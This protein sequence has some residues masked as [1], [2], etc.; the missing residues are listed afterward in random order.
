MISAKKSVT[1]QRV[2]VGLAAVALLASTT[3]VRLVSRGVVQIE[4]E[5]TVLL[6]VLIIDVFESPTVGWALGWLL[7]G[8]AF[9]AVLPRVYPSPTEATLQNTWGV[10]AGIAA[11]TVVVGTVVER[12][13]M[14]LEVQLADLT[15]SPLPPLGGTVVGITLI[16]ASLG[17]FTLFAVRHRD[18]HLVEDG[19]VRSWVLAGR[20]IDT[21]CGTESASTFDEV[22]D[23][24]LKIFDTL[25]S[26]L[27]VLGILALGA[28]AATLLFPVIELVTLI[29]LVLVWVSPNWTGQQ[30]ARADIE[31]QL[32]EAAQV[33]RFGP[34]GM[35]A[36]VLVGFGMLPP[37]LIC[38]FTIVVGMAAIQILLFG[39]GFT[40]SELLLLS[41]GLVVFG[42]YG[43]YSLW[44]WLRILRRLPLFVTVWMDTYWPSSNPDHLPISSKQLPTRPP[45]L[46]LQPTLLWLVVAGLL[47]PRVEDVGPSVT[48]LLYC[49]TILFCLGW[50]WRSTR[51]AFR[52]PSRSTP[53]PP[54]T[55]NRAIPVAFSVQF[56]GY[57]FVLRGEELTPGEGL[58]AGAVGLLE[59]LGATLL[60]IIPTVL[61]FYLFDIWSLVNADEAAKKRRGF[62]ALAV[63][64]VLVIVL[65]LPFYG[66]YVSALLL[67]GFGICLV[68][69]YRLDTS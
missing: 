37:V 46:L 50:I 56:G 53:Q 23:A 69:L 18:D 44:Y 59:A 7:Y 13:I 29:V 52:P 30:L 25:V 6:F 33:V 60:I 45:G 21:D 26:I 42:V 3:P 20:Q 2:S 63:V 43:W 51:R 40:V 15:G 68:W 38:L 36:I 61:I 4:L 19:L 8:G 1:P 47:S 22:F 55:D 16:G 10:R 17:V 35:V 28:I 31:R 67:M 64:F 24:T 14:V 9:Y 11:I 57:F 12:S 27:W 5:P 32:L 54:L 62:V 39:A 65:G 41:T 49:L 58:T 48:F 34:K 66:W